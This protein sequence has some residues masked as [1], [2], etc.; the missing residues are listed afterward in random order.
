MAPLRSSC[1]LL[2]TKDTFAK[3][4][5]KF[6]S[7]P[8]ET[9]ST[10]RLNVSRAISEPLARRNTCIYTDL[11]KSYT[12]CRLHWHQG[13]RLDAR[14]KILSPSE[15]RCDQIHESVARRTFHQSRPVLSPC[16]S[17]Y[18]PNEWWEN[19]VAQTNVP[20]FIC[21]VPVLLEESI[22]V[23][24]LSF[25]LLYQALDGLRCI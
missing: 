8:V 7:C 4:P 16:M 13:I 1:R 9:E 12:K 5:A 2:K 3:R 22:T 19:L 18:P 11:I 21:N 20:L 25:I 17:V 23:S 15:G 10:A 14:G 6:S 24:R